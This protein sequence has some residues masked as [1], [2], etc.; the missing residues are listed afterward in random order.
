MAVPTLSY[1]GGDD[2]FGSWLELGASKNLPYN[3]S[4]GAEGELRMQDNSRVVDRVGVGLNV[5]Y[6]LN[7]YLKFR[8]AYDFMESY[9]PEKRKEHYKENDDGTPK[10]D[11]DGNPIWNGYKMVGNY[12]SPKHR[13]S[14]EATASVKL[15]KWLRLSL[16]ERYQY[17]HRVQTDYSEEKYRFD[18]SPNADGTY[19]YI[20]KEDYPQT[21][22]DFKPASD[23]NVLRSRLKLEVDKKRLDWSP[24]VSVELHNDL[25]DAMK[26]QK[27]R[28]C[29]GTEYKINR[30]HS[31]S[32]A[33]VLTCDLSE[34]QTERMHAVSVGYGFE[35]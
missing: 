20:L 25:A 19:Q 4:V 27:V 22:S 14:L 5:S 13:V 16:R 12:W 1:A 29:V 3:F 9:S 30:S 34:E 32:L 28:T 33:Y 35:F 2:D 11:A 17:T 31:L 7:K 23:D 21:V 18:R 24:F 15:W 10:L 8:A 6:K 26:V